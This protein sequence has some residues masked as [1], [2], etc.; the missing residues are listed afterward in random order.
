MT[1]KEI[2]EAV[3]KDGFMRYAAMDLVSKGYTIERAC[4]VVYDSYRK[5]K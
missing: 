5:E 1:K 4:L 3:K 2:I